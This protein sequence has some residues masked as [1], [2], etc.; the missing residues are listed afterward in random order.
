MFHSL[1][2]RHKLCACDDDKPVFPILV[3]NLQMQLIT[4]SNTELL[5]NVFELTGTF[6]FGNTSSG[7][8]A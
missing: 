1:K 7:N 6:L 4:R 5:S 2:V 3:I 8:D